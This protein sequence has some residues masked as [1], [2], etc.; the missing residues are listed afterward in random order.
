[1]RTILSAMTRLVK[2][3]LRAAKCNE[4]FLYFFLV[5]MCSFSSAM[6]PAVSVATRGQE[7]QSYDKISSA[8]ALV[9]ADIY[10]YWCSSEYV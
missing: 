1:M 8:I 3:Q 5:P 4:T 6:A 9:T 2:L 7:Q 10:Y